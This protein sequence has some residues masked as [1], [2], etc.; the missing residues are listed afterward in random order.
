MKALHDCEVVDLGYFDSAPVRGVAEVTVN[1]RPEQVFACLLDASAWP[2]WVPVITKVTWTSPLPF[3]VGTTRTVDMVGRL[4]AEEHFFAWEPDRRMAFYFTRT[5]MPADAFAEDY[6]LTD[7]G[8]GRTRVRWIM[9][10]TPR[11]SSKLMMRL[12]GPALGLANRFMLAKLGR[13]CEREY[14]G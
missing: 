10:M 8:D 11:G 3:A 7:L 13:L 4:S 9:A 14:R 2:R 1:A 12:T 6:Q 5:S